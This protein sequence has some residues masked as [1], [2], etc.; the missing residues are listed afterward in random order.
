[1]SPETGVEGWAEAE[2]QTAPTTRRRRAEISVVE[3][4]EGGPRAPA[5]GLARKPEITAWKGAHAIGR[6]R[7]AAVPSPR[8][9]DA[10]LALRI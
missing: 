10:E 8:V 7:V 9:V 6:H 3:A 4:G 2:R 1:M 5:E